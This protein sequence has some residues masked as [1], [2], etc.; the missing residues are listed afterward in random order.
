MATSIQII[1]NA[2]P[3]GRTCYCSADIKFNASRP[4]VSQAVML[5]KIFND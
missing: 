4:P 5:Q 3:D 2:A 1:Q